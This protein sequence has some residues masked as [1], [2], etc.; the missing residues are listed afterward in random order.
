MTATERRIASSPVPDRG[1]EC[2]ICRRVATIRL[3]VGSNVTR[4]CGACA[5][6]LTT[7]L[8]EERGL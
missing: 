6:Q 3:L 8:R 1:D 4:L 2:N 7:E 5:D